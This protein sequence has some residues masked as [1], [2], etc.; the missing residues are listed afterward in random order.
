M[1]KI[2]KFYY[3]NKNQI[4]K[5]ILIIVSILFV[6]Q[7]INYRLKISRNQEINN[8]VN[9]NVINNNTNSNENNSINIKQESLID[10]NNVN[11]QTIQEEAKIIKE[12][13]NYCMNGQKEEAYNLLS[14]DCKEELYKDLSK[15]E[16][17]YI[18]NILFVSKQ[19]VVNIENWA[20]NL[21]RVTIKEDI[22]AT[23]NLNS[24]TIQDYIT[25]VSEDGQ[26]KININSFIGKEKINKTVTQDGIDI[27]IA[28]R[29][30]FMD[31]EEYEIKIDNN[32]ENTILLDSKQN[33]KSIYLVDENNVKYYSKS[34]ELLDGLLKVKDGF[35]NQITVKFTKV[36]SSTRTVKS[37]V[38]SDVILNYNEYLNGNRNA[39]TITINF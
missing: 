21:Y 7:I 31:Y 3:D 16:Q 1:S 32:T 36:Y 19:N 12:F 39:K 4:W 34:H 37:L 24:Q 8:T 22:M 15:F 11:K 17:N 35:S 13:F 23:G 5:N 29:K 20:S 27:T 25:V 26:N 10:S 38:F 30:I 18:N 33:T 14:K 9:N 2:R 28:T 6:I